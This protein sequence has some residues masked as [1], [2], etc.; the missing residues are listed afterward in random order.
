MEVEAK[1]TGVDRKTS[2]QPVSYVQ[3]KADEKDAVATVNK[4]EEAGFN[5]ANGRSFQQ[6]Q[7]R[8]IKQQQAAQTV[9][10][11]IIRAVGGYMT[12]SELDWRSWQANNLSSSG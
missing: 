10:F 9:C 8:V 1:Y 7:R 12:K 6:L 2:N 4:Q 11:T 3:S 5:N